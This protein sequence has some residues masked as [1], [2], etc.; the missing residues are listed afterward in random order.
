MYV[1]D[2]GKSTTKENLLQT[3]KRK[4]YYKMEIV[5]KGKSTTKH[6]GPKT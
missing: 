2:H 4:M 5:K 6:I 3:K 1:Q